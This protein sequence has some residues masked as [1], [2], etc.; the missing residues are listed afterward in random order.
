MDYAS[1]IA[2]E[3]CLLLVTGGLAFF[4]WHRKE[5]KRH[6]SPSSP[7]RPL[8]LS[9]SPSPAAFDPQY[10]ESLVGE[11]RVLL[12]AGQ[13]IEAVKRVREVTNWGL[14]ASKDFVDALKDNPYA[15]PP[16]PV[17]ASRQPAGI[18]EEILVEVRAHLHQGRKIEAIKCAREATGWGL[19]ETKDYIESLV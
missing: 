3:S 15:P 19:K 6:I 13:K 12:A 5:K 2:I 11:V 8:P 10:S 16:I 7:D 17:Q 14:K 1:V 9:S 4:S 18:T